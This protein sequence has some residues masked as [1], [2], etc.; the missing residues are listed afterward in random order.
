MANSLHLTVVAEG[1]E[2]GDQLA[3]LT[4]MGCGTLSG[5]PFF[6]TRYRPDEFDAV[7][8]ALEVPRRKISRVWRLHPDT[9]LS[10]ERV[11]RGN[12]AARYV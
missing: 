5:L 4:K 2:T 11:R 10:M 8:V 3:L 12:Q 9:L 1:V 7:A 6:K